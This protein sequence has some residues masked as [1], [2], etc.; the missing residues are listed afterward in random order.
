VPLAKF[1][2]ARAQGKYVEDCTRRVFTQAVK[3]GCLLPLFHFSSIVVARDGID[4][5]GVPASD[6]T[7]AFSKIRFK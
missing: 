4:L 2:E 1:N 5:S 3:E 6:E 7:V